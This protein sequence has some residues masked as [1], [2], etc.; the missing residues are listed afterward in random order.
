MHFTL[1]QLDGSSPLARGTL[2]LLVQV[3]LTLRLIP[4]RAGNTTLLAS[5]QAASAAHPRS[6]GEHPSR[7]S[8]QAIAYGSSPLARGTLHNVCNATLLPRL[9]PA[10]A[11][12][13]LTLACEEPRGAAHPRSRGEHVGF[14]RFLFAEVGSSPL[15]RGTP[16]NTRPLAEGTRLIPARAG[17]TFISTK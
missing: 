15:A 3:K 8:A 16:G 11:G 13:T 2:R 17:N 10:R 1:N 7:Y 6:R 5:C 14:G 4:A 12:N 9:I